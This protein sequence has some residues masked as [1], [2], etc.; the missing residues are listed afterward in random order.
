MIQDH[1]TVKKRHQRFVRTVCSTEVVY[2]LKNDEGFATSSSVHYEEADG[3]PVGMICF[4]AEEALASSCIKD[5]WA[6]YSV[7]PVSLIDFIE[8]WCVGMDNDGLLVGT[9]FDSNMFGYEVE[10]LELIVEL[11]TELRNIHKDLE[12]R[13]FEGY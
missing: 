10:P 5:G 3:E 9:Q 11:T 2:G 4:W 7:V 6:A 13:K 1:I 12:F 8:N